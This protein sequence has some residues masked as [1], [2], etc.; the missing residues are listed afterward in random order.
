MPPQ[1]KSAAMKAATEVG[2]VPAEDPGLIEWVRA[3]TGGRRIHL[4]RQGE[5]P[6]AGATS[7]GRRFTHYAWGVG[8][9][10]AAAWRAPFCARCF[11]HLSEQAQ[12]EWSQVATALGI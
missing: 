6:D 10:E 9:Q 2:G 7:C 5:E 1:M 12:S 11:V 8:V 4:A 3:S